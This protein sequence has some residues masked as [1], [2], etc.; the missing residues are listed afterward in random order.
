MDVDKSLD[1]IIADKRQ[2]KPQQQRRPHGPRHSAGNT[3]R[4]TPYARPPPR[5]TSEKWTHDAY[6]GPGATR[7]GRPAVAPSRAPVP[8]TTGSPVFSRESPRIEIIGLHYEV[9]AEDLKSIFSQAGEIV[10]GPTIVKGFSADLGTTKGEEHRSS[11]WMEYAN[12]QQAKI[13][14]NKFDGAMTKGQTIS[15]RFAVPRFPPPAIRGRPGAGRG[16]A[17]GQNLLSRIQGAPGTNASARV[18][19][20]RGAKVARGARGGRGR[21]GNA[22]GRPRRQDVK[23]DDLDKELDSF[24]KQDAAGDVDMS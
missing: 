16:A 10:T 21:G 13:A 8:L 23:P 6:R 20:D 4:Q 17:S 9:S 19:N 7:G 15:I 3:P 1:D 24:M 11:A 12:V 18:A 5:S 2:P 22:G 14:I